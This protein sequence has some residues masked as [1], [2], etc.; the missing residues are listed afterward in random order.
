M[1]LLCGI[2]DGALLQRDK[3]GFCR[4]IFYAETSG[5]LKT[6]IGTLS[7][8]GNGEYVLKDIPAGGPYELYLSDSDGGKKLT[9]W[10]GDLW[11]LAGQSNME[12]AGCVTNEVERETENAIEKIRCYYLDARW[13]KAVPVTHEPWLSPD[14]CIGGKWRR[15]RME[16]VWKTDRPDRF[17]DSAVK[18]RAVGP[19]YYFAKRMYEITGV[20]Q[21]VIPCALGGANGKR[22]TMTGKV[23]IL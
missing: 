20:P 13:D 11:L 21:G 3:D 16:S 17:V 7:N 2:K 4:C 23:C 12:G 8:K 15:E 9:V 5:E 14:D 1:K 18:L 10:V 22:D 19:G 6:S